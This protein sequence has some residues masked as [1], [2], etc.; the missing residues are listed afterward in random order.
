MRLNIKVSTGKLWAFATVLFTVF[1]MSCDDDYNDSPAQE[2][3]IQVRSTSLGNVLTDANGRTLYFFT[4]DTDGNSACTGGCLDSWP[5]FSVDTPSLGTGLDGGNFST[6][7]RSEGGSQLTY[8][9]WPLYYFS[10]DSEQG[11]VNGEN[12]GG[13]WFVA[14]PDYDIMLA[15]QIVAGQETRYLV[16]GEGNSLYRFANDTENQSNCTGGCL[17]N[18]PVFGSQNPVLPSVLNLTDFGTIGNGA[19]LQSTFESRPLYYFINDNVRGDVNGH[20]VG[21]VWFLEDIQ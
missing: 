15:E 2:L 6:I 16:D 17:D 18:W 10:G 3:D 1:F 11:D 5:V 13:R 12:V 20:E 14:K 4:R 19:S 9:G 8:K 7:T 21:S